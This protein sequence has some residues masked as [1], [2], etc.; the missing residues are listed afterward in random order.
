[1]HQYSEQEIIKGCR[2]DNRKCQEYLY[3]QYYS[4][5]MKICARYAK[6]M[7]D[8]EQLVNDGFLRIFRNVDGF[9]N[10]GSF[11]GWMKRILVNNCLDYLKSKQLRDSLQVSYA[12]TPPEY[13]NTH[14]HAEAL[15]HIEFKELLAV[16]QSLPTVSRTVFNMYVFDGFSHKEIAGM[17]DIS[18][19]TSSWHVHH[20]RNLL[21]KKL[22]KTNAEKPVYEKRV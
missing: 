14:F 20:A 7:E 9:K 3:K 15:R 16:I 5:F 21:Q 19:G 17:L 18:E 8:A 13:P 22:K 4:L 12:A 11:E 6:N 1:M 10:N 2:E